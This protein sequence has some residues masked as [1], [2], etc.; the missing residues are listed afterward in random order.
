MQT[1]TVQPSTQVPTFLPQKRSLCRSVKDG[2]ILMVFGD[3]WCV[4]Q[5]LLES[6]FWVNHSER[7]GHANHTTNIH[8]G[9]FYLFILYIYYVY[10]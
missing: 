8:H 5:H 4:V 9:I 6:L 7:R 3:V 1:L 10:S 2:F